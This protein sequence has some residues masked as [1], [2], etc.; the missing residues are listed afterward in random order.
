MQASG[1]PRNNSK[2]CSAPFAQANGGSTNITRARA[3]I[4]YYPL[5]ITS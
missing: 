5:N 4:I 2:P 1:H 3:F